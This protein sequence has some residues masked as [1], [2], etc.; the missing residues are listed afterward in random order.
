MLVIV[1]ESVPPRLRGFLARWLLEV[2][3]GVYVGSYSVRVRERLW[4]VVTEELEDGNAV[5]A[6]STNNESG[7]SFLTAGENRRE[8]AEF[9]GFSLVKFLPVEEANFLPA[10]EPD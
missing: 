1:T 2:R 5:L 9:D 7:F 8:P 4:K 3:A 6:W 10:E